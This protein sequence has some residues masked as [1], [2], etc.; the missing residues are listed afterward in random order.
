MFDTRSIVPKA[1][2][3]AILLAPLHLMGQGVPTATQELQLSAFF[4]ATQTVTNLQGGQNSGIISGVD[5]TVPAVHSVGTGVELR[6]SY[7]IYNNSV[8]NQKSFVVGPKIEY[9]AGSL[10]LYADILIGRGRI[11]YL[12]GG[13][14][15][16]AL[17]YIRSDSPVFSP[18]IGCDFRVTHRAA[19]K[20]DV[21]YQSWNTPTV[22]SGRIRSESVSV[23]GVYNFDFNR[24]HPK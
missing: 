17:K 13:Y 9:Q 24:R 6:G 21:Q 12:G 23:G 2:L 1:T 15:F 18:G 5:L 22:A 8:S 4:L 3:T 11:S 16:G 19:L 20:V 14:I 7:P 10:R